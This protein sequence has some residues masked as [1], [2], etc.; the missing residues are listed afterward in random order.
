MQ[1]GQAVK[2]NSSKNTITAATVRS[3]RSKIASQ[4]IRL[5]QINLKFVELFRAILDPRRRAFLM[6][7]LLAALTF[8]KIPY[9]IPFLC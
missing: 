7:P 5:I 3:N 2:S 8:V 1:F 9:E 4:Q 6:P